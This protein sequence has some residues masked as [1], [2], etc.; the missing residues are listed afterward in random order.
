MVR[1]AVSADHHARGE[2][3]RGR[4]AMPIAHGSRLLPR[5]AAGAREEEVERLGGGAEERLGVH[6]QGLALREDGLAQLRQ[7]VG[8]GAPEIVDRLHGRQEAEGRTRSNS[9]RVSAITWRSMAKA[10]GRVLP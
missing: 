3:R 6:V 5:D 2:G 9:A 10:P 8:G 7:R 4:A 1:G